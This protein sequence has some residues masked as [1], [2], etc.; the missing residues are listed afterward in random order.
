M[1]FLF[2]P[3]STRRQ[4]DSVVL[5]EARTCYAFISDD[6]DTLYCN[7]NMPS[8]QSCI[9][10]NK[11]AATTRSLRSGFF[12]STWGHVLTTAS[13]CPTPDTIGGDVAIERL[14]SIKNIFI[15][16]HA[17]LKST[18]TELDYYAR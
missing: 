10:V 13:L 7:T 6:G 4:L 14:D 9:S 1:L 12:V 11:D 5:V 2:I 17:I 18:K 16:H 15:R 8:A 3:R